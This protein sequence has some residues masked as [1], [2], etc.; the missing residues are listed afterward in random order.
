MNAHKK[1]GQEHKTTERVVSSHWELYIHQ[2]LLQADGVTVAGDFT[3]IMYD[4]H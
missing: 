4:L 3:I 2:L 1:G